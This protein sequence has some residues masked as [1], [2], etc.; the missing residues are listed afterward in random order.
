MKL[1]PRALLFTLVGVGACQSMQAGSIEGSF[2]PVE[3]QKVFGRA[4]DLK[5]ITSVDDIPADGQQM[6]ATIFRHS[7]LSSTP[8][9]LADM[10]M[11]WSSGDALIS[12]LP[13]GQHRFSA[14]S[15][16]LIAIIYV[17]GG[18]EVHYHLILAPRNSADFCLFRIPSLHESN[19]R[20][21]VIQGFV[22]P[23]RDQTVSRTP[24]CKLMR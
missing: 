2:D 6:L 21:T 13:W 8:E 5:I 24:E 14:V 3:L 22:R 20:M 17:T 1:G 7:P 19:L 4:R 16:R 15:D 10:G 9:P 11:E 23:D 18:V 12:G